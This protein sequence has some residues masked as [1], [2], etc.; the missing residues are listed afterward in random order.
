MRARDPEAYVIGEVTDLF[1]MQDLD[2][3][4][5][6]FVTQDEA[7]ERVN[8]GVLAAEAYGV[9]TSARDL[10]RFVEIHL[11]PAREGK[12]IERAVGRLLAGRSSFAMPARGSTPKIA[13]PGRTA[14]RC[15]CSH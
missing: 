11:D 10:I 12:T 1:G 4:W 7:P 15:D 6:W 13:R 5:S 2:V 8:P 3:T 14:P 9:K